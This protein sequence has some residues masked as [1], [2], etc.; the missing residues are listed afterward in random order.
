MAAPPLKRN[1][2]PPW[3]RRA[4]GAMWCREEMCALRPPPQERNLFVAS[5]E[6]PNS[7]VRR[8]QAVFRESVLAVRLLRR[9]CVPS[10]A[11]GAVPSAARAPSATHTPRW[12][13]RDPPVYVELPLSFFLPRRGHLS[14]YRLQK[15]SQQ[16]H[17]QTELKKLIPDVDIW[18]CAYVACLKSFLRF[19]HPTSARV[20]AFPRL[21]TGYR[22]VILA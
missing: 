12:A 17:P 16:V 10:A 8:E 5:I 6:F 20:R 19:F 15:Q 4:G 7:L 22:A 2:A 13:F 14:I 21:D 3:F 1:G 11:R 18:G 9:V